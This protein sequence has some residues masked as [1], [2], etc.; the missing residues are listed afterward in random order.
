MVVIIAPMPTHAINFYDFKILSLNEKAD[1]LWEHGEFIVTRKTETGAA[2][3]YTLSGFFVELQYNGS[4][5]NIEKIQRFTSYRM[6]GRYLD[7]I[8]LVRLKLRGRLDKE[9][10]SLSFINFTKTK[11]V[12]TALLTILTF[13]SLT[14]FAQ[15]Q[16]I[17][18]VSVWTSES[19]K[20]EGSEGFKFANDDLEI[21][22]DFWSGSREISFSI[23]NKTNQAITIDWTKSHFILWNYS[24]DFF[25]GREST[26]TSSNLQ[27]SSS[28]GSSKSTSS[29]EKIVIKDRKETHIPPHSMISESFQITNT[30]Y[31]D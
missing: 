15:S 14:I 16:T 18:Q 24:N 13:T 23:F 21:T 9:S 3:L 4:L 20:S 17:Y 1:I 7:K 2:N 26:F 31:F 11:I 28:Y 29:E 12:K 30:L 25:N 10:L 27:R 5:N 22:Y 6:L 19:V 8:D